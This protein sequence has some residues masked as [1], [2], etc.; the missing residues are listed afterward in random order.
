MVRGA[1]WSSEGKVDVG[2]VVHRGRDR[3]RYKGACIQ[4]TRG[5]V[6]HKRLTY[7][8]H[9]REFKKKRMHVPWQKQPSLSL[10]LS[11][12]FLRW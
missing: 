2:R 10:L 7:Q 9:A 1:V 12:L 6:L 3:K 5:R 11:L 4:I 8:W